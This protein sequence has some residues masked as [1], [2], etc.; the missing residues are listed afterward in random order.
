M[1]SSDLPASSSVYTSATTSAPTAS[2]KNGSEHCDEGNDPAEDS[3]SFDDYDEEGKL[4]ID[5]GNDGNDV[6]K[7]N[8]EPVP[9]N[10]VPGPRNHNNNNSSAPPPSAGGKTSTSLPDKTQSTA[11]KTSSANPASSKTS[12]R[13]HSP[14]STQQQT[15]NG[16]SKSKRSNKSPSSKQN[17]P[18]PNSSLCDATGVTKPNHSASGESSDDVSGK[19]NKS[20]K[21]N[22]S[23]HKKHKAEKNN[24]SNAGGKNDGEKPRSKSKQTVAAASGGSANTFVTSSTYSAPRAAAASPVMSSSS[25]SSKT[26][27]GGRH[28]E[29][30]AS[31]LPGH[32]PGAKQ[33]AVVGSGIHS[34][35]LG[36]SVIGPCS[37]SAANKQLAGD[38]GPGGDG[39]ANQSS[40]KKSRK[41]QLASVANSPAGADADAQRSCVPQ[42]IK[43]H[44]SGQFGQDV[45]GPKKM[46]IDA[47]SALLLLAVS[48]L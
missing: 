14:S 20:S 43:R 32:P 40:R 6:D 28:C 35:P 27:A 39:A 7:S 45:S 10:S 29:L 22:R 19:K 23:Q 18:P 8:K 31:S 5:L 42:P 34:R 16:K 13:S 44:S 12:S 25:A 48:V 33:A 37:V 9:T 4:V 3:N 30:Q 38:Q 21:S 36:R 26:L 11:A 47:V 46:R 24:G 41:G 2:A 17:S 1:S 15:K